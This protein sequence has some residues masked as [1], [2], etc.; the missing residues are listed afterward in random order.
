[1][2]ANPKWFCPRKF[3]WGLGIKE[4][5]GIAYIAIALAIVAG[6]NILPVALDYKLALSGIVI[7]ILVIDILHIMVQVYSKLDEREQMHQALAERNASFVA[8]VG[9]V[10]YGFYEAFTLSPV[11]LTGALLPLILIGLGM[12]AAKGFTLLYLERRS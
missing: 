11:V 6:I 9:L 2:I 12:A 8:V 3:G 4:W 7:A 10:A 5:Q 1:M